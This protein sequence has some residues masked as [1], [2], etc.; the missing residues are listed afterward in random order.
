MTG[1]NNRSRARRREP[2][3]DAQLLM[4]ISIGIFVAMYAAAMIFLG[5]GFLKAQQIFDLLND[6]AALII[7][8]CALTVVM[9]G[10]GINISVGGVRYC[11]RWA[12]ASASA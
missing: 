3:T 10:G 2:L 5:G 4:T 8:A 1:E 12:S 7:I 11:W 9:I 6:N